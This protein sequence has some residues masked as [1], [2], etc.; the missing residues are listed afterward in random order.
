MQAI[1]FAKDAQ[2]GAFAPENQ[3][4]GGAFSTRRSG[5]H[6]ELYFKIAAVE[7]LIPGCLSAIKPLPRIKKAKTRR[8]KCRPLRNDKNQIAG[9]KCTSSVFVFRCIKH[10]F[11]ACFA[12]KYFIIKLSAPYSQISLRSEKISHEQDKKIK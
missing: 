3:R 8:K 5:G 1:F 11:C 9:R 12:K 10:L 7:F 4:G 6:F 2:K